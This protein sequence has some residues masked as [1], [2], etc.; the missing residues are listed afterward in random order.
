MGDH[1]Y[2]PRDAY[3]AADFVVYLG[4]HGP[5]QSV[6][7]VPNTSIDERIQA[8]WQAWDSMKQWTARQSGLNSSVVR[9]V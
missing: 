5:S 4:N 3:V 7:M 2:L 6:W 8:R 1:L 9:H